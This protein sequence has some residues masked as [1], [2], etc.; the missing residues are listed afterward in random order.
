MNSATAMT[1]VRS[2]L[3][4]VV[5]AYEPSRRIRF[6]SLA[7][8][9]EEIRGLRTR[10]AAFLTIAEILKSH[11]VTVSHET[12]RRFYHEAIEQKP[13]RRRRSRSGIKR[14]EPSPQRK[15]GTKPHNEPRVKVKQERGPRIARIED[16]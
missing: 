5:E 11:S 6:K 12:V 4:S 3:A 9:K 1:E 16:L 8:F 15:K 10:G 7:P 13:P 2:A 14:N